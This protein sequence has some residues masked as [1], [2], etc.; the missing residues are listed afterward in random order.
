M[1]SV[2]KSNGKDPVAQSPAA[3]PAPDL[4]DG[5]PRQIFEDL[6]LVSP[7][8]ADGIAFDKKIRELVDRIHPGCGDP[9]S[10][11]HF[12]LS[13]SPEFNACFVSSA[14]P[15]LIVISKG[16]LFGSK[17]FPVTVET[18]DQLVW[19][20]AIHE[21]KHKSLYDRLGEHNNGKLEE[22]LA[23][24]QDLRQFS[25]AGFNPESLIDLLK[26]IVDQRKDDSQNRGLRLL[27]VIV[28][29]SHLN[30]EKRL[31]GMEAMVTQLREQIGAP[32]NAPVL[33]STQEELLAIVTRSSHKSHLGALQDSTGY[34]QAPVEQRV[35]LVCRAL[36]DN[37]QRY[38]SRIAD[39]AESIKKLDADCQALESKQAELLRS[40][41]ADTI[42]DL[43][44]VDSAQRL[45]LYKAIE[46]QH[47][48]DHGIVPCGRLK[49]LRAAASEL[50]A[51]RSPAALETAATRFLKL[52]ERES[53]RDFAFLQALNWPFFSV[54]ASTAESFFRVR[55][56]AAS[57]GRK[58]LS[59][60]D[61]RAELKETGSYHALVDV[62]PW[63]LSSSL[64]KS[65][66][67]TVC[68]AFLVLGVRDPELLVTKA[69]S[70]TEKAQELAG[71]FGLVSTKR[72]RS[73]IE[74][75]AQK[76]F[77]HPKVDFNAKGEIAVSRHLG[78]WA[79]TLAAVEP[80]AAAPARA[81]GKLVI[82]PEFEQMARD[83]GLEGLPMLSSSPREFIKSNS[84]ILADR[85]ASAIL[86]GFLTKALRDNDPAAV[87]VVR[88]IFG[89]IEP[90][91]NKS[92]DQSQFSEVAGVRIDLNAL[93]FLANNEE[94]WASSFPGDSNLKSEHEFDS[95]DHGPIGYPGP[96]TRI[97]LDNPGEVFSAQE[98]LVLMGQI[99]LGSFRGAYGPR[100]KASYASCTTVGGQLLASL[101]PEI[102]FSEASLADLL[103]LVAKFANSPAA[104]SLLFPVVC[105]KVEN[106]NPG[107]GLIV[108][109]LEVA[110]INGFEIPGHLHE[111]LRKIVSSRE[112]QLLELDPERG[113]KMLN[114]L[115]LSVAIDENGERANSISGLRLLSEEVVT[116]LLSKY[117]SQIN[118]GEFEPAEIKQLTQLALSGQRVADPVLR[119]KI[120]DLWVGS[121]KDL[122]G[123]EP[124]DQSSAAE[125]YRE[126]IAAEVKALLK[127]PVAPP[128]IDHRTIL[129]RLA[130]ALLTQRELSFLFKQ[131]LPEVTAVGLDRGHL[132]LLGLES[133]LS[134]DDVPATNYKDLLEHL[135]QPYSETSARSLAERW[136][137]A[138][139]VVDKLE[140]D[141]GVFEDELQ[142]PDIGPKKRARIQQELLLVNERLTAIKRGTEYWLLTF[143]NN[144]WAA[145]LGLRAVVARELV[146]GMQ[147]EQATSTNYLIERAFPGAGKKEISI[148]TYVA[149]YVDALPEYSKEIAA[150]AM[151][152]AAQ[153]RLEQDLTLGQTLA[154]FLEATGPFPQ[155]AGQA[156][157][158]H[159]GVPAEFAEPLTRLKFAADPKDRW[160]VFE[161]YDQYLTKEISEKVVWIGPRLGSA[162][163]RY[164]YRV[165]LVDG[166]FAVL[167][168]L[169]DF[170]EERFEEGLRVARE[171]LSNLKGVVSQ[172]DI[173]TFE[174]LIEEAER[175]GREELNTKLQAEKLKVAQPMYAVTVVVEGK[176]VEFSSTK[177]LAGAPRNLLSTEIPGVH[178]SE[179]PMQTEEQR[180][181][182][183]I[184][185]RAQLTLEFF[186]MMNGQFCD[187]RHGGN[188]RVQDYRL[189][190]FDLG[191]IN[192]ELPTDTE[193]T[194]L[195]RIA[196]ESV[197]ADASPR[198]VNNFERS[199]RQIKKDQGSV[200][201]LLT[202][203]RKAL[204]ALGESIKSVSQED[205]IVCFVSAAQAG[206][207]QKFIE[208][209]MARATELIS[210]NG[211]VSLASVI[212][213]A[214]ANPIEVR[215]R[216]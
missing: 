171:T 187:D 134:V 205:L 79:A 6:R 1:L 8:S 197:G 16:L 207:N 100:S 212:S 185:A 206:V 18:L 159:P 64:S 145:P 29:D 52:Y 209:A 92:D 193:F 73:V 163:F 23:D 103:K 203:C 199:L 95:E 143:Y 96:F 120:I 192:L 20:V 19:I 182:K 178:F 58:Y 116:K 75:F 188:C 214:Q 59:R 190:N 15:Q 99:Q 102:K 175:S 181:H 184:I 146:H 44:A 174:E 179:L 117:I 121:I 147:E 69:I 89:L 132:A 133:V 66:R 177:L 114:R 45:E 153:R 81:T 183:R 28:G 172:E 22:V 41:L 200:P 53:N 82:T 61:A 142:S 21:W 198:F 78:K 118:A 55:D 32:K 165:Q 12:V 77:F 180:A 130:D 42:L 60:K 34:H 57:L 124:F 152:V 98:R 13:D 129:S 10:P 215:R 166:S 186:H 127:A 48:I 5:I 154:L 168:S 9:A 3:S 108:K 14:S 86:M 87:E 54:E 85:R 135:I 109:F 40:K 138:S 72:F 158:S 151:L 33:L 131:Y 47:G 149:A 125:N 104:Q 37:Q 161:Q 67:Q 119:N 169:R 157:S 213:K 107:I 88:E 167:S 216:A 105:Q 49:D 110:S 191:A 68:R 24:F 155:K 128:P 112:Q 43:S 194:E 39:F 106:S 204:M 25:L 136:Y 141:K 162:S 38:E 113:I 139:L 50:V 31:A 115:T 211:G 101:F 90:P 56:S 123:Q 173:E 62:F 201:V 80:S 94:A 93:S 17:D 91:G 35:D 176:E 126:S 111:Y 26:K 140:S 84:S 210:S 150:A 122:Y 2:I 27:Q 74:E 202:R 144:F 46:S 170:A 83:V 148:R 30:D 11:V 97:L 137:Q 196:I 208:S 71:N 7:K 156:A 51:A 70:T 164:S 63:K 36:L 4:I 189:G 160:E 65:A 76:R 195:G